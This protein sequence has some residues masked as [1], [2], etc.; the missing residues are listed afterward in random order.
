ML[1]DRIRI[2][3]KLG[4]EKLLRNVNS[5]ITP[6]LHRLKQT[7]VTEKQKVLINL[8]ESSL[9]DLMSPAVTR[10]SSAFINLTPMEIQIAKLISQGKRTKEI[11]QLLALSAKTIEY[12]RENLREKLGLKNKRINLQSYLNSLQ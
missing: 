10:L 4:E 5:S 7:P 12:H 3:Q 1:I 2:D 6:H 9:R 8:I 11:A